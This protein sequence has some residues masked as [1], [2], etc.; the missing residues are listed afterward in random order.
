MRRRLVVSVVLDEGESDELYRR[1]AGLVCSTGVAA[2][3]VDRRFGE[4]ETF[5]HDPGQGPVDVMV[6]ELEAVA[7]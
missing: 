1:L 4:E 2:W 3:Q 6:Q 5:G 7:T